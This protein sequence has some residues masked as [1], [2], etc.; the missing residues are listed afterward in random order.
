MSIY[1]CQLINSLSVITTD[2][3][4]VAMPVGTEGDKTYLI[5]PLLQASSHNTYC[6]IFSYILYGDGAGALS[7]DIKYT[8]RIQYQIWEV[9]GDKGLQWHK[10]QVQVFYPETDF[11]LIFISRQGYSN[12]APAID[13]ISII[14]GL[15]PNHKGKIFVFNVVAYIIAITANEYNFQLYI[16]LICLCRIEVWL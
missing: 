13:D 11:Q 14:T 8:N 9:F 7:I 15:C 16:I 2:T 4:M 6:V 1:N 10:P 12:L 5:S 3:V